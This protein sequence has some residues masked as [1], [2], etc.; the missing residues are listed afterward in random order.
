VAK[1]CVKSAVC[2]NAMR[3]YSLIRP[4]YYLPHVVA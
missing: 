1:A 3:L 4:S 2:E